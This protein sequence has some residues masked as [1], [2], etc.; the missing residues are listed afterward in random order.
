[1]LETTKHT[2]LSMLVLQA[3][4]RELK[5]AHLKQYHTCLRESQF[6]NANEQL[7]IMKG[8]NTALRIVETKIIHE[9]N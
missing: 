8:V 5:E 9:A 4:L 6:I 7:S 2:N 1:M 3:E